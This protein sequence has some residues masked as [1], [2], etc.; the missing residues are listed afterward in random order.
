M[1][2]IFFAMAFSA[3]SNPVSFEGQNPHNTKE[4]Y[5][6]RMRANDQGQYKLIEEIKKLP[7]AL[8]GFRDELQSIKRK[9]RSELSALLSCV[10]S[11]KQIKEFNQ[12]KT[13]KAKITYLQKLSKEN[14]DY[15][16]IFNPLI[17]KMERILQG[18]KVKAIKINTHNT[19]LPVIKILENI[20]KLK[21][22]QSFAWWN[23]PESEDDNKSIKSVSTTSSASV[24]PVV[25]RAAPA[26]AKKT[27]TTVQTDIKQ[28]KNLDTDTTVQTDTK[29]KKIFD[30]KKYSRSKSFDDNSEGE[31]KELD[32]TSEFLPLPKGSNVHGQT[33][34]K[35]KKY[36]NSAEPGYNYNLE[37][38][39]LLFKNG[40]YALKDRNS[41]K[42]SINQQI[43]EWTREVIDARISLETLNALLRNDQEELNDIIKDNTV[44]QE[45]QEK[46]G[47]NSNYSLNNIKD[48]LWNLTTQDFKQKIVDQVKEEIEQMK[49]K[50]E[51]EKEIQKVMEDKKKKEYEENLRK[52][53]ENKKIVKEAKKTEINNRIKELNKFTQ[54]NFDELRKLAQE[55][56]EKNNPKTIEL[57][58]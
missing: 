16:C 29:Q 14:P 5:I 25:I 58:Q 23:N 3:F 18:K 6:N 31:S 49:K 10:L 54:E 12:K 44:L 55:N 21:K 48:K 56:K 45:L 27:D 20:R 34:F 50:I 22:M 15:A 4:T 17:K 35:A 41:Y 19:P 57:I 9:N 51:E 2:K 36:I 39:K 37:Q 38:L 1:K 28:K 8:T 46:M 43:E 32:G 7:D 52:G 11:E 26:T 13:N 47:E 24:S 33:S 40:V 53:E 42:T 30:K